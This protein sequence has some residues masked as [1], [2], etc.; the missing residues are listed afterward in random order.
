MKGEL[1]K[2]T[3][4]VG[5]GGKLKDLRLGGKEEKEGKRKDVGRKREMRKKTVGRQGWKRKKEK[6]KRRKK[7]V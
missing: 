1:M 7:Y 3:W 6:R 2:L 4:D 5:R